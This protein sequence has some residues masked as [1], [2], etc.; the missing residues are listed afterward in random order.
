VS[1]G[2]A[3]GATQATGVPLGGAATQN[4]DHSPIAIGSVGNYSGIAGGAQAPGVVAL[5]AWVSWINAHGGANGHPI[6]LYVRDD[7]SDPAQNLA[8]VQALVEQQHVVAMVSAWASETQQASAAYL[9]QHGIPVIGGDGTGQDSWGQRPNFFP[10]GDVTTN[11]VEDGAAAGAKILLP[12]GKNKLAILVCQESGICSQGAA[13][14][15]KF[16]PTVGWQI[17]YNQ[18]ASFAAPTYTAQCLQMKGAGADAVVLIMPA[19]ATLNVAQSCDQQGYDPAYLIGYGVT[20]GNFN[21][22]PALRNSI[23]FN[24]AFPFV[25]GPATTETSEYHQAMQQYEP[26]QILDPATA[27]GWAAAKIF[28]AAVSKVSGPVTSASLISALEGFHGETF[29]GL[30]IPLDFSHPPANPPRCWFVLTIQ[31]GKWF[32]PAGNTP[33]CQT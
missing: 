32:A 8:D 3:S 24:T 20:E 11:L 10:E 19:S 18:S 17:V 12:Q 4:S 22:I 6:K 21:T 7:Q 9:Q 5:E 2:A 27:G 33:Q 26:N 23:V 15:S 29:G 28:Q 25:G 13:I 14:D 1:G 30:T 16:A 31:N